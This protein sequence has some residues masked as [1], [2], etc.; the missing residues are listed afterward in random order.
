MTSLL[1]LMEQHISQQMMA[2]LIGSGDKWV[3]QERYL[4]F[5]GVDAYAQNLWILGDDFL[6][7]VD[8]KGKM[9]TN[10]HRT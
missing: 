7:Q 4:N 1:Q 3:L 2:C 9:V 5:V 10:C 8:S 6:W